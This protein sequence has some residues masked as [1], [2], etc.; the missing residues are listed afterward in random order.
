[1]ISIS[2]TEWM[3]DESSQITVKSGQVFFL[4]LRILIHSFG[5]TGIMHGYNSIGFILGDTPTI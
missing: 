1:M 5:L 4:T 2:D 3:S